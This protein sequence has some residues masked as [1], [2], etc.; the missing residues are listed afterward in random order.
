VVEH[1]KGMKLNVCKVVENCKQRQDSD[2]EA[3]ISGKNVD[4]L[5]LKCSD[6]DVDS[7]KLSSPAKM[8]NFFYFTMSNWV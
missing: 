2:Q 1:S 6:Y 4:E 8:Y 5:L 7:W 3:R